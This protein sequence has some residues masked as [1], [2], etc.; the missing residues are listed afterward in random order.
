[1]RSRPC[2]SCPTGR[3]CSR[4]VPSTRGTAVEI[5]GGF[6]AAVERDPRHAVARV[7][8]CDPIDSSAAE[9]YRGSGGRSSLLAAAAGELP[10]IDERP[11]AQEAQAGIRLLVSGQLQE[12]PVD[13]D[14]VDRYGVAVADGSLSPVQAIETVCVVSARPRLLHTGTFHRDVLL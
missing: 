5:D 9:H 10:P 3:A 6:H 11:A 2:A 12:S 13:V 14:G 1:M 4:L 7:G 8:G